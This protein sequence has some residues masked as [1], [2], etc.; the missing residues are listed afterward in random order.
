MPERITREA[1]FQ[2]YEG[3]KSTLSA[4]HANLQT[5]DRYLHISQEFVEKD[6]LAD[7]LNLT[8]FPKPFH[9]KA[10]AIPRFAVDMAVANIMT[11]NEPELTVYFPS[12]YEEEPK[13]VT[14]RTDETLGGLKALQHAI[15]TRKSENPIR[16]SV[17]H[18]FGHG[19]GVLAMPPSSQDMWP[20]PPF[21][22][23]GKGK[24]KQGRNAKQRQT[25]ARWERQRHNGVPVDMYAVHPRNAF[26][27]PDCDPPQ[28]MVERRMVSADALR[29]QF[30][31]QADRWGSSSDKTQELLIYCDADWYACYYGREPLLDAQ[32]GANEEGVAPNPVGDMWYDFMW[33]GMGDVSDDG[34]FKYRMVGLILPNIPAFRMYYTELNVIEAVRQINGFPNMQLIPRANMAV[35]AMLSPAAQ[36]EA[37]AVMEGGMG[38]G[39]LNKLVYWQIAPT[40]MPDVSQALMQAFDESRRI[41]E[42]GIGPSVLRGEWK[43]EPASA[44]AGRV[45]QARL[46]FMAAKYSA[47][48]ALSNAYWRTLQWFKGQ[49][50]EPYVRSYPGAGRK[51][52][53]TLKPEYVTLDMQIAANL[54]PPTGDEIAERQSRVYEGYKMKLVSRRRAILLDDTIPDDPEDEMAA[55]DADTLVDAWMQS[56]EAL[57]LVASP[58]QPKPLP[59]EPDPAM[60]AAAQAGDPAAVAAMEQ[61]GVQAAVDPAMMQETVPMGGPGAVLV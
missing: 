56:P 58:Q 54:T 6:I 23:D 30:P 27:D 59:A 40:P 57:G 28:W 1:I 42:I 52:F 21:D 16:Q 9:A 35:E 3:S 48:Q 7:Y 4:A 29:S 12:H 34:D 18:E 37:K 43:D 14:D 51:R 32:D 11:G 53:G 26:F 39:K 44:R 55:I 46:P 41:I 45:Q 36:A 10:P 38:P 5:V 61:G 13:T 60:M 47:E 24:P 50:T 8:G 49:E 22:R 15:I 19:L 2:R 25:Y 33:S 17:W 20:D 31:R